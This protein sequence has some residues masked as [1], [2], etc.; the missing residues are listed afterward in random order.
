MYPEIVTF[1][2]NDMTGAIKMLKKISFN[3]TVMGFENY[4]NNDQ[5]PHDYDQNQ[6]NPDQF[7]PND[8]DMTLM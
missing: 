8:S 7:P 3:L 6:P 2:E 1:C 4:T 5:F